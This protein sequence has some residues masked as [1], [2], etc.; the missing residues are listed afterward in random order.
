[1]VIERLDRGAVSGKHRHL[2]ARA[3][4]TLFLGLANASCFSSTAKPGAVVT[5]S[6]G[7][8]CFS[9]A[10][11]KDTR[12]GIPMRAVTVNEMNTDEDIVRSQR[13]KMHIESAEEFFI[14]PKSCVRHGDSPPGGIQHLSIPLKPYRTYFVLIDATPRNS[15]S[16]VLGYGALFCLQPN[17]NGQ[18]DLITAPRAKAKGQP[19]ELC[20]KPT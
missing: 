1:M 4:A 15:S 16:K 2:T 5:M 19:I 20:K 10:D 8:P 17:A 6:G 13:W 18:L 12:D 7:R 14:S 9:V 11:D 3:I